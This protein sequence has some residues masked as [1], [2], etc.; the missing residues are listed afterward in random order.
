M[1][2]KIQSVIRNGLQM[3]AGVLIA[4]GVD[5]DAVNAAVDGVAQLGAGVAVW[6]IMQ[7]W[8]FANINTLKK[9]KARF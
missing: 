2:V 6:A 7:A 5:A 3:F 8:S 4:K 1:N 9:I